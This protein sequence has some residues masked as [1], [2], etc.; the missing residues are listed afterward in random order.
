MKNQKYKVVMLNTKDGTLHEKV[1][2]EGVSGGIVYS[3]D[4]SLKELFALLEVEDNGEVNAHVY[5]I[6]VYSIVRIE[7]ID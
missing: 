3:M 2:M 1:V 7:K 5:A 6:T 4:E